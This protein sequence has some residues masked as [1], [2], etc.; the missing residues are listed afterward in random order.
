VLAE[1]TGEDSTREVVRTFPSGYGLAVARQDV[2]AQRFR[3]LVARA[4]AVRTDDPYTAVGLLTDALALWRGAALLDTGQGV[5]C[6]LAYSSLEQARIEAQEQLLRHK[7]ALGLHDGIV[8]ELEQL[9]AQHPLRER[10]AEL[11]MVALY[12]SGRQADAIAVYQRTRRQLVAELGL[13]PGEA[14]TAT[15]QAILQHRAEAAAPGRADRLPGQ[16][17]G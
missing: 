14:L 17:C 8:T 12:R 16:P 1:R 2:D 4:G 7:L 10:L 15:L 5:I 9:Q 3:E 11:L 13:E 6:R